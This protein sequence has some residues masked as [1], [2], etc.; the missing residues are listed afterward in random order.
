[1]LRAR[2]VEAFDFAQEEDIH[3]WQERQRELNKRGHDLVV[4]GIPGPKTTAALKAEGYRNGI[5]A[6]GRI[7]LA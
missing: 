4:D 3:V 5:W 1:M 2:G 6:L 7:S